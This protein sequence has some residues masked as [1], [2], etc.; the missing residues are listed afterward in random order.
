MT[1]VSN[2]S[3]IISLAAI[4]QIH[5]LQELYNRIIIPQAVYREIAEVGKVDAS[6]LAVQTF[7]WIEAQEVED[8][9]LANSMPQE[10]H[11]GEV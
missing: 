2:T 6:A 10:L 11:R 7:T 3:P 4:G 5:L 1:V 8:D 9:T